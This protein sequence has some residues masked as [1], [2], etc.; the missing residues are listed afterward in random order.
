VLLGSSV[1]LWL[2]PCVALGL[3]WLL[4][5]VVAQLLGGLYLGATIAPNHKGMPTWS[6][7]AR[8][9]FVERQVLS[10]RNVRPGWLVDF[11]LGGLNYQIEHHLFP[12]MPR[13][14]LSRACPI[15]QRFCAE[16][17]LPYD[18]RGALASY[19]IILSELQRV[20]RSSG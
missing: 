5:Y 20:G 3:P 7:D 11:V 8:L 19:R 15:V 14:H 10:S 16:H 1:L 6:A 13:A 9:G 12:S 17:N 18:E 2:A 4:T